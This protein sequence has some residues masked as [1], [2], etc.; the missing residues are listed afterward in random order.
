MGPELAPPATSLRAAHLGTTSTY[1]STDSTN[2][3][4]ALMWIQAIKASL[5]FTFSHRSR[6][7]CKDRRAVT[8]PG[9]PAPCQAK[10][11]CRLDRASPALRRGAQGPARQRV[12]QTRPEPGPGPCSPGCLVP[13]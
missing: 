10:E 6:G 9:R 12:S 8:P 4:S 5:K 13:G 1:L 2:T 3:L 11:G 7:P